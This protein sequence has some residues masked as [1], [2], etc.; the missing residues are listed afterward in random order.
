MKYF[1]IYLKCKEILRFWARKCILFKL[2]ERHELKG[3]LCLYGK[4]T[5]TSHGNCLL[6]I[7][8]KIVSNRRTMSYGYAKFVL[9]TMLQNNFNVTVKQYFLY[10]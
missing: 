9:L 8:I 4:I 2:L 5:L 1:A 3:G 6:Y 10:C 7:N